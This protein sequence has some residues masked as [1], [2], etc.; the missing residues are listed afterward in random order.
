MKYIPQGPEDQKEL[1]QALNL[2]NSNDVFDCIPK[3]LKLTKVLDYPKAQSEMELRKTFKTISKLSASPLSF[4]GCGIYA[5]DIPSIVP[6]IQGRSEFS[7]AYTPYQPEIS[8]GL[9]QAIFEFQTLVCQLTECEL[10]NA[11]LYDGATSLAEGALMALR[12][13]KKTQ[14]KILVSSAL[15]P[16]YKEV[17]WS[18]LD[19]FRDRILEIPLQ[20]D[21]MNLRE[22]ETQIQNADVV[23]TQSPNIFGVIENYPAI[24]EVVKK[25]QSLWVT[26]TMEPL[27]FGLIRG[28]GRFG[29][30]IVTAEG[31][32]F[33]NPPYLGGSSYGLFATKSEYLRNL[34]GRLVGETVDQKGRRSYTLTFA[35]REQFIRREKATSNICTNQNLNMLAG[36]IHIVTLGKQGIKDL[37]TQ[38]LSLAEKTKERIRREAGLSIS[39]SPTFNEFVVDLKKPAHL[40]V[41][42]ASNEDWVCGVDLGRF[43]S[44]WEKKLAVH[45]SE[46]HGEHEINRLVEFLKKVS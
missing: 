46:L 17:L 42:E 25:S 18:Y 30:H 32:S 10:S 2:K 40:Y 12:L 13:K 39:P 27:S 35:T 26:S 14:G 34:P 37:A 43:S 31:Q 45:I 28:P 44:A 16:F 15:H 11:S 4:A 6:F 36:L 24:G 19:H 5:H 7:T 22:L 41:E 3:E 33:G 1:L 29:A 23:I 8:Q 21:S 9:L 20:G 38:N